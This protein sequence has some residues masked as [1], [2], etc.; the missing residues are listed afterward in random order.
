MPVIRIPDPDEGS[1]HSWAKTVNWVDTSRT[2][3]YAFEGEWLRRGLL[4]EVEEGDLV[5]LYDAD[6]RQGRS[7]RVRVLVALEGK[8]VPAH[9]EHGPLEAGGHSSASRR[10]APG[11]T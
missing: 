10:T 4:A 6:D 1:C 8:L 3:G 11:T 5:L 9:D 7:I 2:D